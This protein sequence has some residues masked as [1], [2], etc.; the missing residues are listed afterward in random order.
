MC[1]EWTNAVRDTAG[2]QAFSA[3]QGMVTRK[4]LCQE[5]AV[6]LEL[7]ESHESVADRQEQKGAAGRRS[8]QHCSTDVYKNSGA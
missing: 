3:G 1:T 4:R 5:G 7:A 2:F 8:W 6:E